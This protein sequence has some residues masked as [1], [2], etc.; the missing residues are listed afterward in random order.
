MKLELR[1]QVRGEF[2]LEAVVLACSAAGAAGMGAWLLLGLPWPQ[3]TF[4]ALFRIPCLTCG[5]T[6]ATLALVHGNIGGAWHFN[7]LATIALCG[8]AAFDLYAI[9]VLAIGARRFRVS[10]GTSRQRRIAGGLVVS[11]AL[12]NWIY[13]LTHI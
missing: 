5:S 8:I 12:L 11:V 9:V 4:H 6:R 1:P 10:L 7:P 3:C 2:N 13:L